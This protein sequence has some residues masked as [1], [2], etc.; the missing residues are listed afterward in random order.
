MKSVN[1]EVF[2]G[3]VLGIFGLGVLLFLLGGFFIVGAG[4]RGVLMTFGQVEPVSYGEGIHFKIPIVQGVQIM[5]VKTAKFSDDTEASSSDLQVVNTQ[6]AL[7]YHINPDMAYKIYQDI[8]LDF[9]AKVIDPAIKESVKAATA[10]YTAEQIISKRDELALIIRDAISDK[11]TARGI[12]IESMSIVNIEFSKSFNDAIESKVTAQQKKLQAEV[13]LQR[14]QIEANQTVT[15]A[16]ADAQA[17]KIK[18]EALK[19][20]ENLV[21][22]TVANTWDGHLPTVMSNGGGNNA[23]L[24]D[25]SNLADQHDNTRN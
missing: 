14:I 6:I 17:I 8:G 11:L 21:A 5:D 18:A 25:I 23:M 4:E 12:Y 19:A 9:E 7:N 24:F 16:T 3:L 1:G 2:N 22:W 13:D 10:K 15:K 20:N